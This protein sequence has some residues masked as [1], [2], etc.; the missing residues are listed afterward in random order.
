MNTFLPKADIQTNES[1]KPKAQKEGIECPVCG[2]SH[3]IEDCADILKL[4]IEER[5]KMI[6]K[7]KLCYGSYQKV[8]RMHNAKNCTNRKVCKV[9]S[10]KHL[11]TLHGPVL[12][13]DNSQENSEK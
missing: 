12:R 11:T 1:F 6:F 5:I 10:G 4:S 13:K 2:K 9:C 7:N 3:G 8:L